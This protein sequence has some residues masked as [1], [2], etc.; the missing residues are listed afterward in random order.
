MIIKDLSL[1]FD[2]DIKKAKIKKILL[3]LFD[4][5]IK[6]CNA[7]NLKFWLDSGTLLGAMRDGKI[8]PWDD[9][10]DIMMPRECYNYLCL[11]A[12]S[13][14]SLFGQGMTFQTNS[15]DNVFEVH[16]KLRYNFSTALTKRECVGTHNRGMFIDIFPL[17]NCADLKADRLD[18]HGFLR[19]FAKHTGYDKLYFRSAAFATMN[20]VL[21]SL[22]NRYENSKNV[23]NV[24]WWRYDKNVTCFPKSAYESTNDRSVIFEGR[25]VPI[26]AKAELV[27][28]KWYGKD[29]MTP[30]QEPDCHNA[31]F[32]PFNSYR[33][34]DGCTVEDYY[35][36]LKGSN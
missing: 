2:E 1:E 32:D 33:L 25:V 11:L 34:Y 3:N 18:V 27:L 6:V 14:V 28:E 7:Y 21:T 22:H 8:I 5:F 13:D 26:P 24:T 29:W 4:S 17:D 35:R 19:T 10:I 31:F 23:A 12:Q 36:L 20:K 15:T 16:A 9:D 30:R